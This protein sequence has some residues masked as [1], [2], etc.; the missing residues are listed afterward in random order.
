MPVES[1]IPIVPS[2]YL[3]RPWQ[4]HMVYLRHPGADAVVHE[5]RP[6]PTTATPEGD[7][8]AAAVTPA[9]TLDTS[10]FSEKPELTA[11]QL[12]RIAGHYR[13]DGLPLEL[14]VERRGNRAVFMA[15]PALPYFLPLIAEDPPSFASVDGGTFR[16]KADETGRVTG[17]EGTD[18]GGAPMSGRRISP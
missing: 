10:Q 8:L 14:V 11:Q 7:I 6:S 15:P 17:F 5:A 9:T 2:A 12:D 13:F 4:V 16:F 18:P 1:C 3:E